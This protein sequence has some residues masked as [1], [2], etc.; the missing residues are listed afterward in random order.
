MCHKKVL[1]ESLNIPLIIYTIIISAGSYA[2]IT[3]PQPSDGCIISYTNPSI[4]FLV[5]GDSAKFCQSSIQDGSSKG[6]EI[7]C[8]QLSWLKT[9]CTDIT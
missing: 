8:H 9:N 2:R 7:Y 3:L 1:L 4:V 6:T 5:S